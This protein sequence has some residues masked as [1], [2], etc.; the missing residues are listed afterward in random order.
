[1]NQ[2][3]KG[4]E[5][6]S[7]V[8][9]AFTF[10][11]TF[12]LL[13]SIDLKAQEGYSDLS[14][15][16]QTNGVGPVNVSSLSCGPI[17]DIA[18]DYSATSGGGGSTI[19]SGGQWADG[20]TTDYSA[21][22]HIANNGNEVPRVYTE[23]QNG[24]TSTIT[25]DFSGAEDN[26]E[27]V[28][29]DLDWEDTVVISAVDAAGGAITDCS[30]W[31]ANGLGD[32]TNWNPNGGPAPAPSWNG[33]TCTTASTNN[34]NY[35]RSFLSL[36]PDQAIQEVTL[37]LSSSA[38]NGMHVYYAL[39]CN[40]IL[41]PVELVSFTAD[42]DE[43]SALLNWT[44]ASETD[45]LGFEVQ[46]ASLNGDFRSAG[47]VDGQGSSSELTDYS[48]EFETDM[49]GLY[50]FRLKQMDFDGNF[51]F[52]NVIEEYVGLVSDL[53]VSQSYPNPNSNN[54]QT[55]IRVDQRQWVTTTLYNIDGREISQVFS[56]VL[57]ANESKVLNIET[58]TL[59]VGNYILKIQ[60]ENT[61]LQQ[62]I[63]VTR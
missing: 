8:L 17:S 62:L 48:F 25:F 26:F 2:F 39:Y 7:R 16:A 24:G 54:F 42:S 14:G 15:I 53:S 49:A 12:L 55:S 34:A 3:T 41:L 31:T 18:L 21:L 9:W 27:L 44:T 4:L 29:Y 38:S 40:P 1:M 61:S 11:C 20:C 32:M 60:G 56:G 46:Y 36:T 57:T 33:S 22:G 45:N 43:N 19:F 35:N 5:L 59:P 28:I 50:R 23:I 30:G 63:A 51:E 52:S 37:D 47:F 58:A 13:S 10:T 6:V